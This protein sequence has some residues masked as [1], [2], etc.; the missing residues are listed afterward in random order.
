MAFR[1][2]YC[3]DFFNQ[4]QFWIQFFYKM[5]ETM[6]R[7]SMAIYNVP[8][9]LKAR[10]INLCFVWW[11]VHA[12]RS[13]THKLEL[14]FSHGLR[15]FSVKWL[16]HINHIYTEY[17]KSCATQ[18]P[19]RTFLFSVLIFKPNP[20][21]FEILDSKQ[22]RFDWRYQNTNEKE[23]TRNLHV[24]RNHG[25]PFDLFILVVDSKNSTNQA[26]FV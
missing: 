13:T 12:S 1:Q 19:F 4:Q 8:I 3:F 26:A 24:A 5:N 2:R 14:L 18:Q 6:V 11:N 16:L 20:V 7:Q 25:L 9:H 21:E 10:K 22:F 23:E 15:K 17:I